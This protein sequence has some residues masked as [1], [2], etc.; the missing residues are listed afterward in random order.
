M[1]LAKAKTALNTTPEPFKT[2]SPNESLRS[3][4]KPFERTS[5]RIEKDIQNTYSFLEIS[6]TEPVI[7]IVEPE[8]VKPHLLNNPRKIK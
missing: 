8:K 5:I 6:P 4:F 1:S 7:K 2:H 3:S